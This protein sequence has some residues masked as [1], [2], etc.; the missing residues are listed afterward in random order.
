MEPLADLQMTPYDLLA[1]IALVARLEA[2]RAAVEERIERFLE[3][4]H[5][6]AQRL[7]AEAAATE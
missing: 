7:Y 6:D 3:A 4:R 2:E 5:A 1:E